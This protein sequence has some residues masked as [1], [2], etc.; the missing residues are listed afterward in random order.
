MNQ[1]ATDQIW[2]LYD[3]LDG[4]P[5]YYAR[6]RNVYASNF[7]LQFT[8]LEHEP[9]GKAEIAWSEAHLP[10]ACGSYRLGKT[11]S[12]HDRNIFSHLMC[13]EK[14]SRRNTYDVYP[15]K[16][17]VWALF[18]DWDI[19]WSSDTGNTRKYQYEVVEVLSDH[20]EVTDVD[21]IHLVR[22]KGFVGLFMR[23]SDNEAAQIKIPP[24]EILRFSHKV[25]SYRL[26][27]NERDCIPEGSFELDTAALPV[28]YGDAFSSIS[29]DRAN[30]RIPTFKLT[31]G[32]R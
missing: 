32:N 3:D 28:N 27:G 18:K 26:K 4:M 23:A 22:I 2:A 1:F 21:V 7:R 11:E 13:W 19:S 10:V 8:W 20:A 15:R 30:Q 5:R 25:P 17:E 12:T 9:A 6:I 14:G 29:L 31:E 16:G 24:S